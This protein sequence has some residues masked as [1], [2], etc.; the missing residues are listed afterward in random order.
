MQI[1]ITKY[2]IENPGMNTTWPRG[3][4][5]FTIFLSIPSFSAHTFLFSKNAAAEEAVVRPIKK[6]G[7]TFFRK[8]AIETFLRMHTRPV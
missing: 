4:P 2:K 7:K 6:T 1:P 8:T 3:T 5:I